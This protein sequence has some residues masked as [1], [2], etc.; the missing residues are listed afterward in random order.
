[1]TRPFPITAM[2]IR[3]ALGDDCATVAAAVRQGQSGLVPCPSLPSG[4]PLPFDTHVGI[5]PGPLPTLP[6]TFGSYDTRIARLAAALV[7]DIAG[8]SR[9]AVSRWGPRRVGL[10]LGT[11]TAGVSATEAAY[12][13]RVTQ[14]ELPSDYDFF[15][16]HGFETLAEPLAGLVGLDGPSLVVST[17]CSSSAK[18][19]GTARRLIE[20]DVLDA[21]IVGGLDVLCHTT[22]RGFHALGVLDTDRC[23]PFSG[24][25]RGISLGEGGAMALIERDGEGTVGLLGVGET[26]DAHHMSAPHPEGEGA[27]RAMEEALR[28][29]GWTPD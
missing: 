20:A 3:N 10:L 9:A 24:T 16:H 26:S 13:Q 12:A 15:L 28:R 29:S 25:R 5:L 22:L 1:M 6:E 2:S 21:A 27:R 11:T 19:F 17:A 7:A 23:K 4:P 18:V 14:G 8:A